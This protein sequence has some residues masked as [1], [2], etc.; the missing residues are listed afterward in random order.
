MII[1]NAYVVKKNERNSVS[2]FRKCQDTIIKEWIQVL[3][4]FIQI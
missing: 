2:T 1:L 4:S 3:F